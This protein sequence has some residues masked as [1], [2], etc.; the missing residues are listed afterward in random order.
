VLCA[1][2]KSS[3]PVSGAG[4]PVV[5]VQRAERDEAL[6]ERGAPVQLGALPPGVECAMTPAH[7]NR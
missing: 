5:A 2:A 6:L 4:A 1:C 7:L 3:R